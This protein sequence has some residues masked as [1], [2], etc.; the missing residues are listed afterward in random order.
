MRTHYRFQIQ[1]PDAPKIFER[2]NG[3]P[4]PDIKFFHVDWINVGSKK[5]QVLRHGMSGAPGLE[6]WG[7]CADKQYVLSTIL[8][9]ARDAGVDLVQCG[10]RTY[11]TNTLESGWI[12]SP[13]PGIYTGEGMMATILNSQIVKVSRHRWRTAALACIALPLISGCWEENY[14]C[15]DEGRRLTDAEL[16]ESA[17]AYEVRERDLPEPYLPLDIDGL[18]EINPYCCSAMRLD[19]PEG[20]R[21]NP[22]RGFLDRLLTEP[23]YYVSIEWDVGRDVRPPRR[24]VYTMS[25]CGHVTERWGDHW[26]GTGREQIHYCTNSD[27]EV[28]LCPDQ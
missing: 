21:D 26:P 11:S 23:Y 15:Q 5:V 1:G 10:N 28:F 14:T 27:N 2:M 24:T 12:P 22:K 6:I 7:P 17:F 9:A 20:F 16:L 8:Q 3:G 4:V 13:L 25:L 19:D 18:K